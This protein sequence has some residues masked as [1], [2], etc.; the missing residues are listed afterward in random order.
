[1]V[2]RSEGYLRGAGKE[3]LSTGILQE[4]LREKIGQ[5][6]EVIRTARDNYERGDLR[7][8]SGATIECKGQPIDPTRYTYNFVEVFEITNNPLH[9]DGFRNLGEVLRIA[10]D[11]LSNITVT[12]N[13]VTSQLGRPP[14]LSLSVLSIH[15]ATFT[16]YVNYQQGGRYIYLYRQTEITSYLRAA[17]LRGLRRGAGNSNED[18]FAV[19]IPIANMQWVKRDDKWIYGG[20]GSENEHLRLLQQHLIVSDY[21]D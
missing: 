6:G 5:G 21:S 14:C 12:C 17:T 10:P 11:Q 13:G 9:S 19:F 18:T 7:F 3:Q 1:M 4:F 8:P 20:A 15:N 16:A 2:S